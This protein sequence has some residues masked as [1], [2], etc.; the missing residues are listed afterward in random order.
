MFN[1][2]VLIPKLFFASICACFFIC[3][4]RTLLIKR[5]ITLVLYYFCLFI[6]LFIG[7]IGGGGVQNDGYARLE[8]FREL[9]R[10]NNLELAKN[11]PTTNSMLRIDL[12]QFKTSKEC[13]EY[14]EGNEDSVDLLEA[15]FI[16]WLFSLIVEISIGCSILFNL[17]FRKNTKIN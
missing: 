13:K 7:V 4:L 17:F 10:T 1:S 2:L 5:K 6:V 14:L 15:I 12:D 16:G 11:N 9:E 3:L 8:E